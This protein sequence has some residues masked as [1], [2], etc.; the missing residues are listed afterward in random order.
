MRISDWSSD[1]CSSDLAFLRPRFAVVAAAMMLL[2]HPQAPAAAEAVPP[3]VDPA[4]LAAN[5]GRD[6]LVVSDVCN[7]LGG[8]GGEAAYRAGHIPGGIGRDNVRTHVTSTPRV[9]RILSEIQ[10]TIT[11]RDN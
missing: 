9:C 2:V 3:L 5:G 7:E 11:T 10:K 4:W 6:G 1:V 8:G